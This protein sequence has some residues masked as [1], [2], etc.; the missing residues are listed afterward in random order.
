MEQTKEPV[1]N[2]AFDKSQTTRILNVSG[3]NFTVSKK[4]F[5]KLCAGKLIL[6]AFK[7]EPLA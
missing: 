1:A 6:F 3:T 7:K 5:N 2:K 4:T